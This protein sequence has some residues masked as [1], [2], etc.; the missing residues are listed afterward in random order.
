MPRVTARPR[1]LLVL[2]PRGPF[3]G[4]QQVVTDLARR[5]PECGFDVHTVIAGVPRPGVVDRF[6]RAG[7][8]VEERPD[9]DVGGTLQRFRALRSCVRDASPDV[10]G[11]H[12]GDA[13]F[14][15]IDAVAVRSTGA[16]FAPSLHRAAPI[17]PAS[18]GPRFGLAVRLAGAL[19]VTSDA[20]ARQLVDA[21]VAPDR[22][23]VL[24]CGVE[25]PAEPPDRASSRATLGLAPDAFV[26]ACVARLVSNKAVDVLID[27][28]ARVADPAGRITLVV[29]GDGPLREALERQ[30]ADL[31][32]GRVVFTGYLDD[33]GAVYAAADVCVVPS[34]NEAVPLV[35]HEAAHHGVPSVA[36]DV[37]G[38]REA[39]RD[40]ETGLVVPPGDRDALAG[41]L[42]TL[43]ERPGVAA[44]FGEA[45]RERARREFTARSMA[46]NYARSFRRQLGITDADESS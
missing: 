13:L 42:A 33:P 3:G 26:V 32:P 6:G 20:Q 41:A 31:L 30:A 34:Y 29:A 45:A 24:R 12:Y 38:V 2:R 18:R 25:P 44:R 21:G 22:I 36:T 35:L 39:I 11:I 19:G 17:P 10:V 1:V 40:G 23:H 37:G 4:I 46:E 9:I 15:M 14:P 43:L 27:A 5:L 28:I 16:V 7:V 8:S